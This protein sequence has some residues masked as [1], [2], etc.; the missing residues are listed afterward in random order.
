[1]AS[2]LEQLEMMKGCAIDESHS[3]SALGFADLIWLASTKKKAQSL[4]HQTESYLSSL[5]MR[6]AAEKY[7]YFAI[8][9]TKGSRH[10]TNPDLRL[11][12]GDAIPY[13]AA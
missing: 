13:S 4:L 10:I 8:R 9:T 6:I 3:F 2:L 7:A 5:G 1:M 12:N 11:A